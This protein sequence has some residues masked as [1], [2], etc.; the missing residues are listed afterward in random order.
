MADPS[1][2]QEL[3]ELLAVARKLR[4]LAD[5]MLTCDEDR[6]LFLAAAVALEARARWT[7]EF[8]PGERP[9]PPAAT[10]ARKPVNL[11]I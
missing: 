1:L 4:C 2:A 5:D 6:E 9:A 7:A 10:P 11:L 3:R 8:L